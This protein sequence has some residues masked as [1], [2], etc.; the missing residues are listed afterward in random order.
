MLHNLSRVQE[1]H[2]NLVD[3]GVM[4]IVTS[5]RI[6][7]TDSVTRLLVAMLIVNLASSPGRIREVR[8]KSTS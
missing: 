3:D 7:G 8:A 4:G 5:L 6:L 1:C 2:A